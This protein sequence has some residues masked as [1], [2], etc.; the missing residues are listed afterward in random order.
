MYQSFGKRVSECLKTQFAQ[1]LVDEQ[2]DTKEFSS[3]M[4]KVSSTM[5][6]LAIE[7]EEA[8]INLLTDVVHKLVTN[9]VEVKLTSTKN[10]V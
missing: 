8:F 7:V 6:A 5:P 3:L 1:E 9:V 10:Q 2:I 4:S